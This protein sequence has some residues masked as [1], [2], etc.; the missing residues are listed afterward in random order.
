M[1]EKVAPDA[2]F[3]SHDEKNVQPPTPELVETAG[4]RKSIALNLVENPLKVSSH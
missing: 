1:D 2:A 3:N 4:R